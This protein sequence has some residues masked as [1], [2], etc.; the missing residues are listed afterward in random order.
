METPVNTV[1]ILVAYAFS[2]FFIKYVMTKRA[3]FELRVL[4]IFYNSFQVLISLY[5]AIE[6]KKKLRSKFN[7]FSIILKIFL[8]W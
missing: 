4:L 8:P 3:A 2:I 1:L 5:I 6:V 7:I